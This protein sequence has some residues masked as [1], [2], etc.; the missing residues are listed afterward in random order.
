MAGEKILVVEDNEFNMMLVF[1][2]LEMA[3][4]QVIQA[5]TA[6]EAL[7]LAKTELPAMIVM[8][9]G[10]PRMDGLTA[11]KLLHEDPATKSIPVV[12]LTAHVMKGDEQKALDAGCIGYIAK[13]LD[14]KN[15]ARQIE[16]FFKRTPK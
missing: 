10:L 9:V 13:P 3:G 14:A 16:D 2:L 8:D 1:D 4:F 12:A 11:T 6:E 5:E 7:E 15:F